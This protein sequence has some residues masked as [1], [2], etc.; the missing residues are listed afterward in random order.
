MITYAYKIYAKIEGDTAFLNLSTIN[1]SDFSAK[2]LSANTCNISTEDSSDATVQVLDEIL[3][4]TSGSSEINL[5]GDPKIY[6]N[7]FRDTSSFYKKEL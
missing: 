7:A 4:E 6:I 3:I 5:Y 2:H 1:S